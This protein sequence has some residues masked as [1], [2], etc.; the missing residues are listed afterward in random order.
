MLLGCGY[1]LFRVRGYGR[2]T[3]LHLYKMY[4]RLVCSYDIQFKVPG[5][6]VPVNNRMSQT[7]KILCRGL[8]SQV[9]DF[10]S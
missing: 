4:T 3:G 8:L 1:I 7:L 5:S 2:D 6:P 9:P 10:F